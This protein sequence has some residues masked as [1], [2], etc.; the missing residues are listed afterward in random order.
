MRMIRARAAALSSLLVALA[1][2]C[3]DPAPEATTP[4]PPS[5]EDAAAS[6]NPR[7]P[8]R[9]A[10]GT[11][12]NVLLLTVDTLR[13]DHLGAYGYSLPTSPRIDRLAKEGVLFTDAITP[14]PTTAPAFATLLTGEHVQ[15]HHVRMNVGSLPEDVPSMAE[16]FKAAGYH[17]AAFYGNE[18]VEEF[19][20][21]FDVYEVFPRRMTD[22]GQESID[23][24]GAP[25]SLEWLETAKEPWFLWLHLIDPHGPYD[26]SPPER[27]AAFE[28]PDDPI[29]E[30]VLE[31]SDKN[32][33]R[34]ALPRFQHMDDA[35]TVVDYVRRYDGEIVGSDMEVGRVLDFLEEKG[36]LDHTLVVMTA[37][38]G[39][40]LFEDEYFFQHG[41]ILNEGSLRIPLI[42]RHGSLPA[43]T[44]VDA[45][46]SLVDLYPT[47]ATLVGLPAP[48]VVGQDFTP[49]LFGEE[50]GERLRIA[51]TV[52]PNLLVSVIRGK[53]R[54]VG[55][56]A[57]H[58][59]GIQITKFRQLRLF[60]VSQHP[61]RRVPLRDQPEIVKELKKE[62][63]ETST[64]VRTYEITDIE[65]SKEQ[66][67]R[68]KVLGYMD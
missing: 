43:G 37:D 28:Y 36:E 17:T 14:V 45:P 4:P 23:R 50:P 53:W 35:H 19:G 39:E 58:E 7:L 11:K 13:R 12:P 65:L 56:P 62:L 33:V 44:T 1:L 16:A 8:L 54:L 48:D 46:V 40:S 60:D 41:R 51:Y 38:H 31:R 55:F 6:T 68:L 67:L 22:R 32:W 10:G 18:A 59:K 20:R 61:E 27:S 52:T 25:R 29:Y 15:K 66:E 47:I 64:A 30:K 3:T 5:A 2:A 42:L 49:A 9:G 26:S 24:L 34:K 63:V 21:G 57:K